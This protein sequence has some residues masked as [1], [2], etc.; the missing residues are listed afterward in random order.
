MQVSNGQQMVTIRSGD[1]PVLQVW[2]EAPDNH[3]RS[4]Q[5]G[6][7][8]VEME[9]ELD[10]LT[11]VNGGALETPLR[12]GPSSPEGG[13]RFPPESRVTVIHLQNASRVGLVEG[14]GTG[15]SVN[16]KP[17]GALSRKHPPSGV[18]QRVLDWCVAC[19][20]AGFGQRASG[21]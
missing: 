14:E 5:H 20:R 12:S 6:P 21:G 13:R 11:K 15:L 16:M 4:A 18:C 7:E 8:P 3:S 19:W 17:G 10:D 2:R 1:S 9:R